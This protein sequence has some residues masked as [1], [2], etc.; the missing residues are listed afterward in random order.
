MIK[1]SRSSI[2]IGSAKTIRNDSYHVLVYCSRC[3]CINKKLIGR[4]LLIQNF[5]SLSI[6]S[7]AKKILSHKNYSAH[8]NVGHIFQNLYESRKYFIIYIVILSLV[9][10]EMKFLHDGCILHYYFHHR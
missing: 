3:S 6:T 10:L 7:A 8:L 4:L 5:S 1:A 2:S 9:N